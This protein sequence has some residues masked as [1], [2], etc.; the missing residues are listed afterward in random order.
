MLNHPKR[1]V[2][3]GCV[4]VLGLVC[5]FWVLK[6]GMSGNDSG[7]DLAHLGDAPA[8][9]TSIPGTPD[10]VDPNQP[11][12]WSLRISPR[13]RRSGALPPILSTPRK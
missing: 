1:T 7:S 4:L 11:A 12:T 10:L 9:G 8:I 2:V 6:K 5:A 3:L 13:R